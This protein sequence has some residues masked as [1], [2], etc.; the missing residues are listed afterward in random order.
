MQTELS[1]SIAGTSEPC[2]GC[3]AGVAGAGART[4][5]SST[6][7]APIRHSGEWPACFGAR[8]KQAQPPSASTEIWSRSLTAGPSITRPWI[9]KREPWQV[10]S[11]VT[12]ASF[13]CRPQPRWVQVLLTACRAPLGSR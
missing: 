5:W 3:E 8:P 4:K 1:S 7:E 9:E 6:Q 2:D 10:Q 12:S 13:H 11:Q